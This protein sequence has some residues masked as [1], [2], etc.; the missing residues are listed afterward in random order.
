MT[1]EELKT[2]SEEV[3]FQI[4]DPVELDL[5]DVKQERV[6][7][8]P[9]DNVKLRVRKATAIANKD[10]SYRQMNISFQVAEGIQMGEEVKYKGSVLFERVC[11]FADPKRYDKD[12]FKKRQHLVQLRGLLAALGEDLAKVVIDDGFLESLA[13]KELLADIRQKPNKFTAKDGTEV[14][15]TVNFMPR[16]RELPSDASV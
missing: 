5:M 9:T 3:G 11:Y 4:I 7:L 10:N 2:A 8:P 15:D 14:N 12:F 1:E 6:L 16:F 13:G